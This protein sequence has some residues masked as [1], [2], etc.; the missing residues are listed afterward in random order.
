MTTL[1]SSVAPAAA[2]AATPAAQPTVPRMDLYAP[3]HKALRLFMTDTLVRV[4][5][6]EVGDAAELAATLGQVHA[7]LDACRHH[8]AH[9]NQHVHTA[10]EARRPGATQ[11]VAAEHQEHLDAI[12]ALGA[13]AAALQALPTAGAAHR[14]YRHLALFVGENLVHMNVE[15]TAHNAALWGE[16]SDAELL[17]VHQRILAS[18]DPAEMAGTLRWMLP[19]LTPAERAGMLGEMQAE[20][21]PEGL[22]QVL[23]IARTHLD[24]TAWARLARALNLPPVP[25]LMSA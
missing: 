20:L 13:D 23:D 1:A 14:L 24:D 21:P 18:I 6:L 8:L 9:E 3:I 4:G 16:F 22:R 25:G 19:A 11:R 5:R 15:E 7:L 12:A 2:P 10:I 17:G